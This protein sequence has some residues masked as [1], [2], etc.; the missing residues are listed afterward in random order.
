M[1]TTFKSM[2]TS[3][4]ATMASALLLFAGLTAPF[5]ILQNTYALAATTPLPCTEGNHNGC[6]ELSATPPEDMQAVP[7]NLVLMLDDSGSMSYDYMPDWGY[8]SDTSAWGVR[9]SA[10]NSVYYDPATIYTPPPKADGTLYPDSPGLTNAYMDGFTDATPKDV[11]SYRA[12]DAADFGHQYYF[13]Q[14]LATTLFNTSD[15]DKGA[16][17]WGGGTS[18][19]SGSPATCPSGYYFDPTNPNQCIRDPV[20]PVPT[21]TCNTGDTYAASHGGLINQCRNRVRTESGWV[22]TWYNATPGAPTCPSGSSYDAADSLCHYPV[23]TPT[24]ATAP[25]DPTPNYMWTCPSGSTT[26]ASAP[27]PPSTPPRCVAHVNTRIYVWGFIYVVGT[28]I[29]ANAHVVVPSDASAPTGGWCSVLYDTWAKTN[30]VSEND[31][32]GAAAPNTNSDGEPLLA[33][34][35]AALTAGQNIANWFS[36][37]RT[38]MQ[39]AK[40]GLMSAFIK[41]DPKYRFG[42]ASINGNGITNIPTTPTA[43]YTFNT[44]NKLAVVQPFGDGSS[45]TQKAAFWTWLANIAGNN[46]TPLRKALNAVGQYYSTAAPWETLPGDPGW[47]TGSTTK[48]TCR[49]AYTILTTDGFWNGATP[50]SPSGIGGAANTDGPVQVVPTGAI[51][52]YKAVPPY[53]GGG[54]SGGTSLT[55]VATYYWERDLNTDLNNEVAG[56][57]KDPAS[58]QHMTT[59]TVGLGFDPTGIQPTGTTM[60]QIFGWATGGA[61]ITGFS[62]PTPASNSIYNIADLAHAGL[63]GHG[64]FFNVKNT[65]E[66]AEAFGKALSDIAARNVPPRPVAVNASVLSLGAAAFRSGY[67]TSDWSG[68][69]QSVTLN[70]DGTVDTTLWQADSLLDSS[71]H[72]ASGYSGRNIYTGVYALSSG[73]GTFTGLKFNVTDSASLDASELAGL[74]TPALAGGD[75][76]L[77]NRIKYL[78][79]DNSYEGAPYRVRSSILG[80]II[81][82]EPTYVAGA[83]GNYRSSWPTL[84]TITPPEADSGA[85]TYDDFVHAASTRAATVYVGANDGILHAFYAPVPN[86][87]GTV[88]TNGNCSSYTYPSG[89]NQ[90][91]EVWGF[92]PRAV[93]ANLGNLTNNVSFQFRPTVDSTPITRDV[94]F[95]QGAAGVK[96]TWHTILT[97]GVGLGGRGVYALDITDPTSFS[98]S[99]VLWEFDADMPAPTSCVS[100]I[101]SCQSTDLGFT[102]SQP[103]VA[104]LANGKWVVLVPNGY[105]PDCS[106]PGAPTKDVATCDA[107]A[108]QAPGWAANAPYSALFVLDAQTGEMLAELKT[109]AITGVTSF[110]LARAVVGD[111]NS[112]QVDDVAFAGDVQ[113]NLWRFNL[114]DT[115]PSNWNVSLVYKGL[116]DSSG[117]QG[118]QPITT[119]PRLFPDPG[120]NRF[121]VVFGTGKYLGVG[122]NTNTS[123][124]SIYAVRDTVSTTWTQDDLTEQFLHESV[125]PSGEPNAGATLRCVTGSSSDTCS[126]SATPINSLAGS[127]GGWYLNLYATDGAGTQSNLGERVVVNP[128]A[129]FA[130]NTVVFQSMITGASGSDACSPS[131]QGAIL[132]LNATTGGSAGMSSLGGWPTA[133]ARINDSRTS[134]SLPV[135]S[136]LGGGRAYLPGATLAPASSAPISVDAPIWRRRSWRVLMHDQ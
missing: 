81:H 18:G 3:R 13:G 127:G 16:A 136:A 126:S 87:T 17:V 108:A 77:D 111:Y 115:N 58:W 44:D 52:N 32:S 12:T 46:S 35:G 97:G 37:Y 74:A 48:F 4:A 104:R 124:Q 107:I 49:A 30:C 7:P 66:L 99:N 131:I 129:I 27:P 95:S 70:S 109:P 10:I 119:M 88:D 105:F 39:M 11:R 102:V 43:A 21:W 72:S 14:N 120:T 73:I 56:G 26:D 106:T 25:T 60:P 47:T 91:Q 112:D 62:W 41:V 92:M 113:G 98:I 15:V 42:F 133:G 121:L 20:S 59:F 71:Y 90:G 68:A 122:D 51:T 54:V 36:Y 57:R 63:N 85:Q 114:S 53:S 103:N 86:C 2:L 34:N 55:D 76:T 82:S 64:D 118:V 5:L 69:F 67:T 40:S 125:V 29:Q 132:A 75:D 80:A 79:G 123:L 31:T 50:T 61:A 101:G 1:S 96:D 24:P 110:G 23:K 89:S 93:F 38:R 100:N 33:Q 65:S 9:N 8:L 128:G 22:D 116:A 117:N 83:T 6:T 135:V 45:G 94:F 134:G 78:L 28:P 19:S 130:S 84:G